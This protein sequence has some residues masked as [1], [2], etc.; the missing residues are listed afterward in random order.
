MDK[1]N[2]QTRLLEGLLGFSEEKCLKEGNL[3]SHCNEKYRVLYPLN[4][5]TPT[6]VTCKSLRECRY[7]SVIGGLNGDQ[8]AH[9]SYYSQHL[10][11]DN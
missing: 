7:K 1:Q 2:H 6:S 5:E 4:S 8:I 9:C 3:D 10:K 11:K